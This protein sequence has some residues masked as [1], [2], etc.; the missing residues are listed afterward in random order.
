[1][2]RGAWRAIVGGVRK[3][4]TKQQ[5]RYWLEKWRTGWGYGHEGTHR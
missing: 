1:M 2:D 4:Q 3:N 5:S